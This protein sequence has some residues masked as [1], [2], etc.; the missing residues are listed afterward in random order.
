MTVAPERRVT[1][2]HRESC[3]FTDG[4]ITSWPTLVDYACYHAHGWESWQRYYADLRYLEPTKRLE[5][6]K[7]W[8]S[9]TAIDAVRLYWAT[10]TMRGMWHRYP[11]IVDYSRW[12]QRRLH[13]TLPARPPRDMP[14]DMTPGDNEE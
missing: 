7:R 12:L 3:V 8:P 10:R 6:L 11:S 1:R 14:V 4:R 5:A 13:Y 2:P 9:R